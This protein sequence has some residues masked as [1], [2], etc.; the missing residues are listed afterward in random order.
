MRTADRLA[1]EGREIAL[2]HL[3]RVMWPATG[4]TKR[5]LIGYYAAIA[6][7]I[8]PHL[9]GRP[10]M[11]GRWPYG[12]ES[13]GFGQFEC[14]ARPEWMGAFPLRL[15][16]GRVVD[17]CVVNDAPSLVWLAQQGVIELHPYL[18][19]VDA[20][21]RP[22]AI[23]LDL[24]PGPPAGLR[25]C[26]RLALALREDLQ[27]HALRASAK[28]SGAAGLHLFVPLNTAVTYAETKAFAR[29]LAARA[30]AQEPALAIAGVSRAARRGRVFIDWAQNDQRKQTVAPYS[31]RATRRPA[32]SL[33]LQWHEIERIAERDGEAAVAMAPR[34]ALARIAAMGD[35]FA[36]VARLRQRLPD[37]PRPT[38]SR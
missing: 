13:R 8:L 31:L 20:F 32:V 14:R 7:A 10:V 16:D 33:P 29:A 11:L 5:E 18:A 9:R 17:V 25:E 35:L 28:L 30:A 4:M 15:R 3:D 19:R 22:T 37:Q 27:R 34:D 2:T 1:V 23:V 24:D 38:S 36:D 6:P 26:A 12:V 21:D